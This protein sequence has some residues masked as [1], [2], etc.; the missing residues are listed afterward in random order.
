MLVDVIMDSTDTNV[1]DMKKVTFAAE[2]YLEEVFELLPMLD[3]ISDREFADQWYSKRECATMV[4]TAN[5]IARESRTTFML[6]EMIRD[7]FFSDDHDLSQKILIKWAHCGHSRRG[8]ECW[9]NNEHQ[10][11]RRQSRDNCVKLLLKTQSLLMRHDASPELLKEELAK[12]YS[13]ACKSA[14]IFAHM[15]GVADAEAV[16][17]H[18]SGTHQPFLKTPRASYCTPS[19]LLQNE[20]SEHGSSGK[21]WKP[22]HTLSGRQRHQTC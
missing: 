13:E 2:G 10:L 6:G 18:Q 17:H 8:L 15:L 14:A 12:I 21:D 3:N 22:H 4:S 7:M 5:M 1:T 20:T 9:V 16:S 19:L 11:Q